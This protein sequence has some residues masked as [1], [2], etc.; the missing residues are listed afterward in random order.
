MDL[1]DGLFEYLVLEDLVCFRD[2]MFVFFVVCFVFKVV[3]VV[4]E[5]VFF[6][7]ICFFYMDV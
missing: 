7:W 5:C 4:I 3:L 1:G 2:G 6:V